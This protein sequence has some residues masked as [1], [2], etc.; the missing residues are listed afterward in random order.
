MTGWL[1]ASVLALGLLYMARRVG[2]AEADAARLRRS[3]RA[4]ETQIER[5]GRVGT[6]SDTDVRDALLDRVRA[7]RGDVPAAISGDGGDGT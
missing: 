4:A 2:R 7:A 5:M 1:V 6:L 3:L